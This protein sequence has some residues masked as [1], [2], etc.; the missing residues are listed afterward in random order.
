MTEWRLHGVSRK[1]ERR[2]HHYPATPKPHPDR[3]LLFSLPLFFVYFLFLLAPFEK[4]P[5]DSPLLHP[6]PVHGSSVWAA[7]RDMM[8]S[9]GACQHHGTEAGLDE[10]IDKFSKV[11]SRSAVHKATQIPLPKGDIA[12]S[13]A[14]DG[15]PS[16]G[17]SP[18]QWSGCPL[19]PSA[20]IIRDVAFN[21]RC[22]SAL[23]NLDYSPVW[24]LEGNQSRQLGLLTDC[25]TS[26]IGF[27]LKIDL[28]IVLLQPNP[29]LI[30]IIQLCMAITNAHKITGTAKHRRHSGESA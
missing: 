16:A 9:K 15:L 30:F 13:P 19:L 7:A 24:V 17:D 23:G 2:S 18:F 10:S 26:S 1:K 22:D 3:Y 20:R 11:P 6:Q 25:R 5:E 14:T 12:Q 8:D 21:L 28:F 4:L 29:V 27:L